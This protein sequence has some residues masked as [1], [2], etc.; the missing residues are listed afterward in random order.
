MLKPSYIVSK[1]W[2]DMI[3]R[4]RKWDIILHCIDNHICSCEL[5]H[6]DVKL[7][8]FREWK[9]HDKDLYLEFRSDSV[10]LISDFGG[11]TTISNTYQNYLILKYMFAIKLKLI[12]MQF[13]TMKFTSLSS[14]IDYFNENE[15]Q[16]NRLG[17]IRYG[18]CDSD[19]D[20][21]ELHYYFEL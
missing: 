4:D 2:N 6:D 12:P 1:T 3:K 8:I 16:W 20:D 10:K 14:A 5:I 9:M 13:S 19:S 18:G 17:D 7:D 21:L 11:I 15:R